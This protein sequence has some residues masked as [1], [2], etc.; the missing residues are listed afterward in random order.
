[1]AKISRLKD[2]NGVVYPITSVEAL[3]DNEGK[4]VEVMTKEG[5]ESSLVAQVVN[6]AFPNATIKPNVLN[7]WGVVDTLDITFSEIDNTRVNE[8]MIE[9]ESGATPTVLNLPKSV[10]WLESPTIEPYMTY[11]ISILNNLALIVGYS[12]KYPITFEYQDGYEDFGD[13]YNFDAINGMT[14]GE[15]VDSEYNTDGWFVSE[16]SEYDFLS[17]IKTYGGLGDNPNWITLNGKTVSPSDL[18]KNGERYNLYWF[19]VNSINF[20]FTYDYSEKTQEYEAIEGMTWENWL[21]SSYNVDGWCFDSD[22]H[23]QFE[24]GFILGGH[25]ILYDGDKKVVGSDVIVKDKT[26]VSNFSDAYDY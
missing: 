8:F 6:Q 13:I 2:N 17:G 9:F 24:E 4:K 21:N 15:W 5:V 12:S 10:R 25:L 23:I 11:Q 16:N 26:Y 18:V 1:M 20:K 14:W 19:I 3:V 22:G 7:V